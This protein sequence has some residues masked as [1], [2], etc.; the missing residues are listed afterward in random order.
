MI[1]EYEIEIICSPKRIVYGAED[2][3]D[4]KKQFLDEN[5]AFDENDL[6][7]INHIHKPNQVRK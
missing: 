1:K 5:P 4:A 2:E 7:D 6:G 3:E